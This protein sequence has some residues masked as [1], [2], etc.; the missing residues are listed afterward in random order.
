MVGGGLPT[1]SPSPTRSLLVQH[2]TNLDTLKM[3]NQYG[4]KKGEPFFFCFFIWGIPPHIAARVGES[5]PAVGS[6]FPVLT[7]C[8][9]SFLPLQSDLR[10]RTSP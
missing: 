8:S 5:A 10:P 1:F 7:P 6:G 3:C 9:L 2:V 4:I